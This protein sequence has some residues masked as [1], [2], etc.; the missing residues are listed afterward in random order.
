MKPL[1]S[2]ISKASWVDDVGYLIVLSLRDDSDDA[3]QSHLHDYL[4][5]RYDPH[6]IKEATLSVVSAFSFLQKNWNYFLDIG[7][8]TKDGVVTG[9]HLALYE[10]WFS[11]PPA[12]RRILTQMSPDTVV[13]SAQKLIDKAKK[14]D[15]P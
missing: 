15:A 11:F 9:L 1:R 2:R 3:R 7:M 8:I 12:D 5:K 10:I 14:P 13:R 6:L 4:S